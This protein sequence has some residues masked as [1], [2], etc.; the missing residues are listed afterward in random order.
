M[1]NERR[2]PRRRRV[3]E[4]KRNRRKKKMDLELGLQ[5]RPMRRG[6]AEETAP[7]SKRED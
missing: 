3:R 7:V 6:M 1:K 4:M 2:R 5:S